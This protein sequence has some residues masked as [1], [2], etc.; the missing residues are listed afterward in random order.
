MKF[1]NITTKDSNPI[2]ITFSLMDSPTTKEDIRINNAILFGKTRMKLF[3]TLYVVNRQL[4]GSDEVYSVIAADLDQANYIQVSSLASG[5]RVCRYI[6]EYQLD[7]EA[8]FYKFVREI[9]TL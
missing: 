3:K 9:K 6:L 5:V 4:L 7:P 8:E 1:E 2:T